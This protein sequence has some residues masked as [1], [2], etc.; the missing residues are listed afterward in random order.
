ML[1]PIFVL[2][3]WFHPTLAEL[4]TQTELTSLFEFQKIGDVSSSPK[5]WNEGEGHNV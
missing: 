5:V 1:L 2:F 4:T 3:G